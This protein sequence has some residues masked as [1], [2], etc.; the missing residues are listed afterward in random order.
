MRRIFPKLKNNFYQLGEFPLNNEIT[1]PWSDN[2]MT[3][4]TFPN[5][6]GWTMDAPWWTIG[7][8]VASYDGIAGSKYLKGDAG[9]GVFFNGI[10]TRLIFTISGAPGAAR[11]LIADGLLRTLVGTANYSNGIHEVFFTPIA[12]NGGGPRFRAFNVAGGT[13]FDIDD[14]IL[15]D[16][17]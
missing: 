2:R 17:S 3:N 1:D 10:Y 15:Q 7:G 4:G 5:A 11:F 16:L 12:D 13:A 14:I 6:A 8:G 9:N